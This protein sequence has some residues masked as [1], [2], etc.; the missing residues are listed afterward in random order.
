M[1]ENVSKSNNLGERLTQIPTFKI[2]LWLSMV[3]MVMMF[4]GL[5]SGYIVRQAQSN[6]LVFDLPEIFTYSTI[7]IVLSSISMYWAQRSVSKNDRG[8]L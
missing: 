7:I 5:T 8:G 3:S 6:W 2:L 4:A 1:E